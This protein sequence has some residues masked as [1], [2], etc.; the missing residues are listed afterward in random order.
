[1]FIGQE[2][3]IAEQPGL[4][5]PARVQISF[6]P[7]QA[8]IARPGQQDVQMQVVA[9]PLLM[10]LTFL[11]LND[12][13]RLS[14]LGGEDRE[15]LPSADIIAKYLNIVGDALKQTDVVRQR[16]RFGTSGAAR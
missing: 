7:V 10:P 13:E 8:N 12:G 9:L 6:V 14:P 3:G 5:Y 2:S 15:Y 16:G 1:V 11:T 4:R